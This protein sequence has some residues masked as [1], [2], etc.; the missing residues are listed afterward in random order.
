[1]TCCLMSFFLL[2]ASMMSLPSNESFSHL[3]TNGQ[4]V[5]DLSAMSRDDL[6]MLASETLDD[7]RVTKKDIKG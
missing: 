2:P 1:M 5:I 7:I 3:M 6:E 4:P